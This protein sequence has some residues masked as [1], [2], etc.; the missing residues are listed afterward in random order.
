[1]AQECFDNKYLQEQYSSNVAQII[2]QILNNSNLPSRL[3]PLIIQQISPEELLQATQEKGYD[4]TKHDE[5]TQGVIKNTRFLRRMA[6]N[7]LNSPFATN[8]MFSDEQTFSQSWSLWIQSWVTGERFRPGTGYLDQQLKKCIHFLQKNDPYF[9]YKFYLHVLLFGYPRSSI[10][11]SL[12]MK[13]SV[14]TDFGL[15]LLPDFVCRIFGIP[16]HMER[17]SRSLTYEPSQ[18]FFIKLRT[19]FR[20]LKASCQPTQNTLA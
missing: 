10:M 8:W 15:S 6:A 13:N 3:Q 5:V 14:F 12:D 16:T 2:L 9:K 19:F 7:L 1:M 11:Y 18:P 20:P 17:F 4:N